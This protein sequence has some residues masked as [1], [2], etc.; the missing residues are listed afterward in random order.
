[1]RIFVTG[2]AGFIGKHLTKKL[3]E[4]H[5]SL[6]LLS[7]RS[8]AEINFVEGNLADI[9]KW[10][11]RVEKFKPDACVHLAW[12]ALPDYSAATSAKNLRYGLD[13]I[14]M[15]TKIGCKKFLSAGSC[16][17][18]G[19]QSGK[20]S[21]DMAFKPLNAFTAAKNSL[22]WLGAEI[23]KENN[24][25]FIWTRLFYVYGP[26]Q[27]E[28]SL[29]PYL[30]NCVK[31]GKTPEIKNPLAKNDFIYVEDV[32]DAIS[33]ILKKCKKSAVYNIGSGK[34]TSVQDII[35]TVYNN[36]N[37]RYKPKYKSFKSNTSSSDNFWGDI[38]KIKR[39]IGWKPKTTIKEGIK[40][41]ILKI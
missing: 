16:W 25:Q 38:S 23:A 9:N 15:L 3:E 30:I 40:R 6:L 11:V 22:H 26:G 7:Q 27:R 19:Q 28:T 34:A 32:A 18:Y 2:G 29:I 41:T 21:E 39:E 5:H 12:E 37:L 4:Q 31:S 24:M 10:K 36:L 17:E 8:L 20:L 1:M 14:S 35:K 33:M 13:L